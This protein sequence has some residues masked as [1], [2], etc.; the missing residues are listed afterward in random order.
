MQL[1]LLQRFL[2][3]D[4]KKISYIIS[5]LFLT[6]RLYAEDLEL[7][8]DA[9]SREEVV[10]FDIIV[11]GYP[12]EEIMTALTKGYRSEVTFTIKIFQVNTG[13]FSFFGDRLIKEE[14]YSRIAGWDRFEEAFFIIEEQND[15]N[16]IF[17]RSDFFFQF[18][19]LEN[20]ILSLSKTTLEKKIYALITVQIEPVHLIPPLTIINLLK[21]RNVITSPRKKVFL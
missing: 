9:T 14:S 13:V 4:L 2:K 15:R 6:A 3:T 16:T 7:S 11:G 20:F 21:Q 17:E 19:S 18:F 5:I 1:K 12:S 10:V 8:V